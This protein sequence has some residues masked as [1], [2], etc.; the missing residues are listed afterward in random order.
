LLVEFS[1]HL[2]GLLL[3]LNRTIA[4]NGRPFFQQLSFPLADL[5]GVELMLAGQLVD[6]FQPLTA[7]SAIWNL[8]SALY[9]LR[10]LEVI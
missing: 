2:G 4:E 8:N 5:I 10:F 9:C 3:L 1:F 6:R 7:S